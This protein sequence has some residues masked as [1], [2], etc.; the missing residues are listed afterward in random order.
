MASITITTT[1]DQDAR[2]AAAFGNLLNNTV[3]NTGAVPN[4]TT[5]QVKVWLISQMQMVVRNYEF[6]QQRLAITIV[7][8]T[9]S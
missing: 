8:L 6:D 4:A 2:L 9:A 3:A 5:A 7:P 1:A